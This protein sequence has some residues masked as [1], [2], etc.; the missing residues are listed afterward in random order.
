LPG[1]SGEWAL[2]TAGNRT[3]PEYALLRAILTGVAFVLLSESV[4][5]QTLGA[6]SQ[7]LLRIETG[8]QH[9]AMIRRIAVDHSGQWLVT[10]S[11]DK[12][13][14][15]WDLRSSAMVR[16][17]RPPID[18]GVGGRL[19]AVAL[20][21]D[22]RT[23][24]LGGLTNFPGAGGPEGDHSIYFFDRESGRLIHRIGG[25]PSVVFDLAWSNDGR[26]LAAGLGAGKGI[27]LW[28]V[29]TR[30]ER[31]VDSSLGDDV[32]GLDFSPDSQRLAVSSR[33]HFLRLY[34]QNN[35]G[36]WEK[37]LTEKSTGGEP[38][39]VRFSP[40]GRR[41]AVGYH[42]SAQVGLFD[43][44]TLKFQE[45]SE[46]GTLRPGN[47]MS[48]AWAGKSPTDMRLLA[49]GNHQSDNLWRVLSW[50]GQALPATQALDTPAATN[51]LMDLRALPDGRVVYASQEPSWGVIGVDGVRQSQVP[52]PLPDMRANPHGLKLSSDGRQIAFAFEPFGKG[53]ARFDLGRLEL[54][55]LEGDMAPDLLAPRTQ[56][57][58]IVLNN[59]RG[60]RAPK[61][62]GQTLRLDAYEPS[63]T[64]AVHPAL[65]AF[66][67]GA[68]WTVRRFD[69]N[70][71]G[72]VREVWKSVAPSPTRA[73]NVSAD[74]R[75]VVAV[76]GDGT[77]RWHRWSDGA[78]VLAL[79]AHTDRQ[80]WVLWTPEGYYAASPGGESLIGW[81]LNQGKDK[82]ARFIPNSQLY[83]VFYRPDIVQ[84][85][86]K[87]ED[88]SGL[89]TLTAEQALKSPPPEVVLAKVPATSSSP[90]EQVCYKITSTGG[91]IGEVRVFQ[92]GKLVKSDGFY[93]E[94]VARKEDSLKL[95]SVNS[96]SVT[97]SLRALKLKQADLPNLPASNKGNVVEACQDI[98]PIA[99]DNELGVVA[100]NAQ[101]TVQS[102]MAE[103]KFVSTRPAE[104]SHLHLLA[105]GIDQF[106][107]KTANLKFA[108]KDAKDF[109]ELVRQKTGT[110]F[111]AGNVHTA[112]LGNKEAT[113]QGI[114]KKI[115][116]LATSI[117]A[118][119]TFILFVASHGVLLG[120]QYYLVSAGY[121]GT[122]DLKNLVGSNEIVE[123]SKK[124]KALNQL[125][126]FDTCHAGGVDNL[127]GGLYD[128]RMSVLAKKMGL[129]IY[130]AAGGLQEALDG[131]QGN[132]LF[133]HSLINS[134]KE[135]TQ[136]DTDKDGKISVMELGKAAKDKTTAISTR[137]GHPQTP[138]MIH[139]GKDLAVAAR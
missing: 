106:A 65:D 125:Y 131:Y 4:I 13:A 55:A 103:G 98:E 48:V 77:I 16:T 50:S 66:V 102:S 75:F 61:A 41:V 32:Y 101:N 89:I 108:G 19:Y 100:F 18:V 35:S 10:A 80:R 133:T 67:L 29:G 24:V 34:R 9:T 124:I 45:M 26:W 115:D 14:R 118:G 92:N 6:P 56:S 11:E 51:T 123:L 83:D 128:A 1:A 107:D 88:I 126:V 111:K 63:R 59:W 86:F 114:L 91:G 84:A 33:D 122:A 57:A 69:R 25:F 81:H 72:T 117:K 135:S 46:T 74:G 70:P 62:N 36:G 105:I 132:G 90:Q 8:Q 2:L 58:A 134:L 129:H 39:A 54:R 53:I 121:D 68:E 137:I 5:A 85:K 73:V 136:T 42:T 37:V 116:E 30:V 139:F 49:A 47:L 31:F 52:S 78:E 130:A 95:A 127:I 38:Y 110:L 93:R 138:T 82:E 15:V 76:Y 113:K 64:Y 21:P 7:P 22:G 3:M 97:R 109:L 87:G 28:E 17:L 12:T 44:E 119:D 71:D 40:D 99:G 20:S 104:E 94:A 60:S 43:A 27:R 112:T 79:F 120:N 23:V 96:E